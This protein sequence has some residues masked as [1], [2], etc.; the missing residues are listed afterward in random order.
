MDYTERVGKAAD[1]ALKRNR[2]RTSVQRRGMMGLDITKAAG[3]YDVSVSDVAKELSGRRSYKKQ[4]KPTRKPKTF[5]GAR[6]KCRECGQDLEHG[7]SKCPLCGTDTS[8]IWG[9]LSMEGIIINLKKLCEDG[10][11]ISERIRLRKALKDLGKDMSIN[12]SKYSKAINK[13]LVVEVKK[14]R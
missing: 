9:G 7:E 8:F 13:R 4:I 2:Q 6:E 11:K 1:L 5:G 14:R 3:E 12:S 10:L